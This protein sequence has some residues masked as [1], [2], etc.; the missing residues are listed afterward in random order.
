MVDD[1]IKNNLTLEQLLSKILDLIPSKVFAKNKD[2]QWLYANNLL[3]KDIKMSLTELKGKS[4]FELWPKELAEKYG[5]DDRRIMKSGKIEEYD[6]IYNVEG[7]ESIVHTIKFPIKSDDGTSIGV[8]GIFTDVTKVKK[9]EERIN[10]QAKEILENATPVIQIINGIIIAPII[11]TL[12]STRT[13][14]IMEKLLNSIVDTHSTVAL[15]DITGV[16]IIDTA[17]AANLIETI[18]AV[19]LLGAQVIVTG[20]RPV[21]AQTMVHLGVDLSNFLTYSSLENGLKKALEYVDMK[22]C[23]KD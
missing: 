10:Q 2:A 6:E 3:L 19:K 15:L 5:V 14:Q 12:D 4:D 18:T 22:I 17:T 9:M 1:K 7:Q 21:I 23:P 20:I 13:Q 16:P 11:G 8:G